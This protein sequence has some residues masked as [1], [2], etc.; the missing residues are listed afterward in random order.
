[1]GTLVPALVLVLAGFVLVASSRLESVQLGRTEF[2]RRIGH[3]REHQQAMIEAI[4]GWAEQLRDTVSASA[5]LEQ[6]IL[7]TE[8]RAPRAI[9]A[10]V[11]K[12]AASLRYESFEVAMRQFAEDVSHPLADFVALALITCTQ[13]QARDIGTL[14]GALAE[15]AR[16]ESKLQLRIWVS[17]ARTRS[18]VRIIVWSVLA[19]VLALAVFDASYLAPF[20]S[21]TGAL[22]ALLDISL[23]VSAFMFL[24]RLNRTHVQSRVLMVQQ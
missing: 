15:T 4:A 11:Q 8:Q 13:H 5:G 7:A 17:R 3:E 20:M 10:H 23:F 12:L 6:A 9:R 19:F 22:L 14:L 18:A 21:Q 1:M 24:S 2:Q 16:E